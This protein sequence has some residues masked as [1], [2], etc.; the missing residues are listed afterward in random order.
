MKLKIEHHN[1]D[2]FYYFWQKTLFD[3]EQNN[4][5][6]RHGKW[7]INYELPLLDNPPE[8]KDRLDFLE[9]SMVRGDIFTPI[10]VVNDSQ[11]IDGR[12]KNHIARSL[13]WEN[14]PVARITTTGEQ[15]LEVDN[16][17][18]PLLGDYEP[19]ALEKLPRGI[20]TGERMVE[21]GDHFIGPTGHEV[22]NKSL[23]GFTVVNLEE[24]DR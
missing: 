8:N 4:Y 9:K 15:G 24:H 10:V 14:I 1:M 21:K 7:S 18:T 17:Y 23:M 16:V 22:L 11:I 6:N 12:H 20:Y 3:L 5:L 13:G 2:D 19:E